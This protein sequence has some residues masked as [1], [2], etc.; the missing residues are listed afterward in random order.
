MS[1]E[2]PDSDHREP[3]L[4]LIRAVRYGLPL[5]I[6]A[7]GVVLIIMGHG[8][9]TSVFASR[10]SLLSAVGVLF[11]IISMMV[12]LFNWLM[13]LNGESEED[14]VKEQEAREHFIRTGRWP[15]DS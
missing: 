4:L 6:A 11:I 1:A 2:Q 3:P 13:R 14:R 9:Y 12:Y 15:H 5:L 10:D 7:A 8:Q